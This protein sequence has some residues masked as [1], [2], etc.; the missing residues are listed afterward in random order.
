MFSRAVTVSVKR[1]QSADPPPPPARILFV[2]W[3][4]EP[5]PVGGAERQA[6]LQAQELVKRGYVVTVVCPAETGVPKRHFVGLVPVR[7]LAVLRRPFRRVSFLLHLFFY[8]LLHLRSYNLV[9][10]HLANLQADA[11]GLAARVMNRPVWVKV[12]CGGREGEAQRLARVARVTRWYG[13]RHARCVQAI[14]SEIAS[15][16]RTLVGVADSRIRCI[17]NGL[18]LDVYTPVTAGEKLRLRSQLGLPADAIIALFLG[19]LAAYKGL[20]TL[21]TAWRGAKGL[22]ENTFLVVVGP[23]A[24]DA[25]VDTSTMTAP[26]VIVRPATTRPVDYLRAAD[27]Y[28]NPS[29][30]D[31]MSNSLLEAMGVGLPVISGTSGASPELLLNGR[32]GL[33]VPPG[34]PEALCQALQ[35]LLGSPDTRVQ[36]GRLAREVVERYGIRDIVDLICAGYVEILSPAAS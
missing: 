15:E 10:V 19:R 21:L 12:A 24:I 5:G 9:H 35:Q 18:D 20:D 14:S 33:L 22:G 34:D 30:A 16:M 2:T 36:L 7:R 17:P 27:L 3:G 32:A 8:C 28:V 1:E 4:F 13:L 26:N 6:R 29:R 11:V 31:G 23:P 25:P